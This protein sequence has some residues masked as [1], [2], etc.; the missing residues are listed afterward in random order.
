MK[1]MTKITLFV[2]MLTMMATGMAFAAAQY[3][4][5]PSAMTLGATSTTSITP[6][7]NVEVGYNGVI[8]SY[9]IT[10]Q[11]LNGDRIFG[12]GSDSPSIYYKTKTPGT[13]ADTDPGSTFST[14]GY[15]AM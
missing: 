12:S 9:G 6:S 1:K 11:H 2:M 13:N 4:T 8:Q 10:T 7:A 14:T 15:T 3:G 5:G